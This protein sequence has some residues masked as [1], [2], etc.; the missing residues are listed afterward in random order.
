MKLMLH[1]S[2]VFMSVYIYWYN[3]G[4]QIISVCRGM[5]HKIF[6]LFEPKKNFIKRIK[7][8]QIPNYNVR[9]YKQPY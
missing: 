2:Y 7:Y 5:V 8:K 6:L 3:A 1:W 9:I 4:R